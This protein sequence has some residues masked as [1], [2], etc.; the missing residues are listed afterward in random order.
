MLLGLTCVGYSQTH[1][2]P[3]LDTNNYFTGTNS[4][5]GPVLLPYLNG[6]LFA[7]SG[8]L[9]STNGPCGIVPA[10]ALKLQVSNLSGTA[11]TA[12]IP[13]VVAGSWLASAGTGTPYGPQLKPYI[14]VRDYRDGFGNVFDC[15]KTNDSSAAWNSLFS[16]TG[17]YSVPNYGVVVF[18]P[19]C[20]LKIANP[21]SVNNLFGVRVTWQAAPYSSMQGGQPGLYWYGPVGGD[22]LYLNQVHMGEWD[23]LNIY[24]DGSNTGYAS[25]AGAARGL[26]LGELGTVTNITTGI[27][28]NGGQ[29]TNPVASTNFAAVT[30]GD[31]APGN[32]ENMTFTHFSVQCSSSKPSSGNMIGFNINHGNAEPYNT[33]I[34][35]SPS[36]ASFCNTWFDDENGSSSFYI[37]EFAGGYNGVD[38]VINNGSGII[39]GGR[40]EYSNTVLSMYDATQKSVHLRDLQFASMGG[41]QLIIGNGNYTSLILEGIA[42]D[43]SK[44]ALSVGATQYSPG[45]TIV[46]SGSRS[47]DATFESVL[48]TAAAQANT[49]VFSATF[50]IW[51]GPILAVGYGTNTKCAANSS[52][53]T[54][55][56]SAARAGS[57]SCDTS[58][59]AG[60]CTIN[61]SAVTANS[62]IFV[63][64]S[65]AASTLLSVTCNT[66]SDTGLTSPRLASIS[67]R[68]SFTINLGTF[69]THPECFNYW[70]VN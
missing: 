46:E 69:A 39:E 60:T 40:T 1:V 58:T 53:G 42:F 48:A 56:C 18:P 35:N 6:C 34:E 25:S 51:T 15:T 67:A 24:T 12:P 55:A 21:I 13:N 36:L 23:N 29:V 47:Y 19:Y 50:G 16:G 32:V 37:R 41:T 5:S 59:S 57:F 26:V 68:T 33:V 54:V 44:P 45:T 65:A 64:P 70:I 2:S 43:S 61:T 28:F 20:Q 27:T 66:V 38:F 9:S 7:S 11:L 63:Q 3:A 8:T 10:G 22:F 4:F 31:T 52:S 49:N 17:P 62:A 30:I 14:D